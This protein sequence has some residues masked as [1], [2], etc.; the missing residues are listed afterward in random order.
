MTSPNEAKGWAQSWPVRLTLL[1]VL[2][3][4]LVFAIGV[5]VGFFTSHGNGPVSLGDVLAG[6]PILLIAAAICWQLI[7]QLQR[8]LGLG[9]QKAGPRTRRVKALWAFSLALGVVIGAGTVLGTK[10]SGHDSFGSAF[11]AVL[12]ESPIPTG[13]AIALLLALAIV[14]VVSIAYYRNIDEH[15]R[16]AQGFASTLAFNFYILLTLAWW[17]AARGGLAPVHDAAITF[18]A[19]VLVW[20]AG[21]L[22][23]KYR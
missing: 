19:S 21:W 7:V 13:I 2:A 15:E 6:V 17:T 18:A 5:L 12:S 1:A 8:L 20:Y 23:Q 4:A 16:A 3:F 22:W 14:V 11:S 9:R 10:E